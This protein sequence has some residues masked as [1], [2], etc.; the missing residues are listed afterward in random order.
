MMRAHLSLLAVA[1][2]TM[3]GCGTQRYQ[4]NLTHEHLSAKVR[5]MPESDIREITRLVSRQCSAP[6]ICITRN[7]SGPYAGQ[8]WVTG[9][10]QTTWSL[11]IT[12]FFVSKR[13]MVFG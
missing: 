6:I 11:A 12:G 5:T 8:V 3:L 7:D 4:W 10:N 13:R 2:T 1:A 9:G